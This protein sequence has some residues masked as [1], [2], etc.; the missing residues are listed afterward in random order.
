MSDFFRETVEEWAE[1]REY[2]LYPRYSGRGM[3][4]RTC[5]G[6]VV[7]SVQDIAD[8]Y[9]YI[10]WAYCEEPQSEPMRKDLRIDNLGRDYVLYWPSVK[11]E[12]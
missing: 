12:Q 4:D 6:V 3:L 11:G 1:D 10:G 7:P 5:L 2:R 9:F 8:L